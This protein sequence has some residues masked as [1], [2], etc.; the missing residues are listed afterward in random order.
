MRMNHEYM[1]FIQSLI[2]NK[3][4]EERSEEN[5][6]K[7][8]NRNDARS[9]RCLSQLILINHCSIFIVKSKRGKTYN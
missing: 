9:R 5:K 1:Y 4:L 7:R 8:A 2:Q 6:E 3:R